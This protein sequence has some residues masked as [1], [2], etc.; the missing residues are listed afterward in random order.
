M[1]RD[2]E[3]HFSG[4]GRPR[5]GAGAPC[6][7]PSP[8]RRLW[9]R[10]R[11]KPSRWVPPIRTP[12]TIRRSRRNAADPAASLIVATDKKA[13]LHVYGLGGESLAFDPAGRLNNVDLID[14]GERGILVAASDR[15]DDANARLQLYRLDPAGPRLIRLGSVAG[16]KGEAYGVCLAPAADGTV[17]AFSVLKEGLI[18]Q[19]ALSYDGKRASGKAVR[20]LRVPSQPEGCVV[21]TRTNSLFIGEEKAGIWRFDSRADDPSEG[22]SSPGSTANIWSPTSKVSR[23][24]RKVRLAAGWSLPARATTALPSIACPTWRRPA[25]SGSASGTRLGRGYGRNRAGPG[26][27]R[28]GISRRTVRGAGRRK[29]APRPELQARSMGDDHRRGEAALIP[30][31]VRLIPALPG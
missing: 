7:Q 25:D 20:S 2:V 5:L 14:L 29:P 23:F 1:H 22:N 10:P 26:R 6:P 9:F 8:P 15:N 31:P 4:A 12:P 17:H 30:N 13:G 19:V 27:L 28:P 21:D 11:P 16:G 24:R 18:E 3:V